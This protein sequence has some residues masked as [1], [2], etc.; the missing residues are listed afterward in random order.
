MIRQTKYLYILFII[1]IYTACNYNHDT[2]KKLVKAEQC[3]QQNVD[4]RNRW[5]AAISCSMCI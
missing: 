5:N 2:N 3:I 1:L 4:N